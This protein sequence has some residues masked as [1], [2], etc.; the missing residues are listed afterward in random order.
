MSVASNVSFTNSNWEAHWPSDIVY[1]P[2]AS[3][4]YGQSLGINVLG[5]NKVC[6]YDCA[7]CDLGPTMMRM[8]QVKRELK[9]EPLISILEKLK[10][11]LKQRMSESNSGIQHWIVAGN[12]EP[13]LYPEFYGL[14]EGLSALR[15]E[16]FPGIPLIL[17][18]NGMHFET[19]KSLLAAEFFDQTVIKL[20][21]GNETMMKTLNSPLIRTNIARLIA[22]ARKLIN[23]VVQSTFVRGVVDN[24]KAELID[25]WIEVVG[26]MNPRKIQIITINRPTAKAGI[27][28]VDEDTLYT[29]ASKL[30]RRT[31]IESAV[32]VE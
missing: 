27:F 3:R 13:T 15:N 30:K 22:H 19:R 2:F 7:Y 18:T 4:R 23:P 31:Q 25:E 21:A 14:A 1:G 32:F 9:F 26:M 10:T 11:D 24:T 5:T 12:G 6:S 17:L 29:I 16:F 8:N 28:P 20:D